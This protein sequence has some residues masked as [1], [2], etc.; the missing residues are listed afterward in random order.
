MAVDSERPGW[1]AFKDMPYLKMRPDD[2][3]LVME[4]YQDAKQGHGY[5]RNLRDSGERYF[6]HPR[7]VDMTHAN[8]F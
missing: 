1:Q 8:E 6:E 2:V 3:E 5:A 7:R 4:A